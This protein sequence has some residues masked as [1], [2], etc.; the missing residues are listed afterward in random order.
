M[1]DVEL[2]N[3][4][5]TWLGDIIGGNLY[6]GEYRP[7]YFNPLRNERHHARL[8]RAFG[9]E[10]V[11][12]Y[13]GIAG[14]DDQEL[15]D[16]IRATWFAE[17]GDQGFTKEVFSPFKLEAFTRHFDCFVLLRSEQDS[18]PPTRLRIWS[19]YEHAW[20]ALAG[21]G[22]HVGETNTFERAREAHRV[23]AQALRESARDLGVPVLEHGAMFGQPG[24]VRAALHPLLNE[25]CNVDDVTR[26]V[27][28]TRRRKARPERS[29]A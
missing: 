6:R 2:P 8:S 22:Y 9:C 16:D 25:H 5:S 20:F 7:E 14:G 18:L 4:G 26:A 19:F 13:H 3:S 11:S 23:M 10:L 15:D 21:A 24:E 28:I 29:A 1:R 12:C 17:L 27:C